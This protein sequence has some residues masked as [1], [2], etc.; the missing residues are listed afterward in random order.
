MAFTG[1]F[2]TEQNVAAK[3]NGWLWVETPLNNEATAGSS[4]IIQNN[5]HIIVPGEGSAPA[6]DT[7][8]YCHQEEPTEPSGDGSI[9]LD[10][11]DDSET[12]YSG[13]G[14][15]KYFTSEE[16]FITVNQDYSEAI[17]DGVIW[18]VHYNARFIDVPSGYSPIFRASFYKRDSDNNDTLMFQA[19]I[20]PGGISFYSVVGLTCYA[21]PYNWTGYTDN[22][23]TTDDRLRIGIFLSY[24][25]PS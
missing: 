8:I 10:V 17:W 14:Y 18:T 7:N 11:F 19:F 5:S 1:Y 9:L 13:S 15:V 6:V 21:E 22:A 25:I 24:G 4:G 12:E 23:I 3:C 20:Q 2:K 16:G